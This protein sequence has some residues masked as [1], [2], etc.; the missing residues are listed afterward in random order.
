MNRCGT[1]Y[2]LSSH[3]YAFLWCLYVFSQARNSQ[4]RRFRV[5]FHQEKAPL[6][7]WICGLKNNM[8]WSNSFFLICYHA[9]GSTKHFRWPKMKRRDEE[10][11]PSD[12]L[13]PKERKTRLA[14]KMRTYL[15]A[16]PLTPIPQP[17]LPSPC[18]CEIKVRGSHPQPP[19]P[20]SHPPTSSSFSLIL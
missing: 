6:L 16:C 18:F 11:S 5:A 20:N 7:R 1:Y 13:T 3:L 15:W 14:G 9:G 4:R 2:P 19:T 12:V 17:H 8:F 10:S